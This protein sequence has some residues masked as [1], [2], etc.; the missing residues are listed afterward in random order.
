MKLSVLLTTSRSAT[1]LIDDG[2]KYF[3]LRGCTLTLNGEARGET[4]KSVF[5]LYG[6]TPSSEYTLT[7]DNG[8]ESEKVSFTTDC[9]SVTLNVRGFGARGDGV[10]DDT[11]FIQ[12]AILCCPP[13]GRVLIPKGRYSITHLFLKSHV[14]I[15]LK[16]GA[17]LAGSAAR[18]RT[19]VLPGV[20]QS[21]DGES[22][23][24]LASWEGNPLSS[25]ASLITGIGVED[26][27]IYGSGEIDGGASEENWWHEP[28]KLRGAWRPRMIYL[29][30]CK[31]VTVQGVT[32]KNSPSWNI[33]PFFSERLRFLELNVISPKDSPNT[34]GFDPESCK[35]VEMLGTWFSVGDDCVAIKSGKIYMGQRYSTPCED[36]RIAH[37]RMGDGH[38]GVTLGSEMAGGIRK[39]IVEDCE[40]EN[41]DRGLRV[42]TRRGRGENGIIDDILFRR[43]AMRG[44]L[45]PFVV[46]SFYFCDPDGKTEY[47]RTR[48]RLPV[49]ERTPHIKALRFS[50]IN[51]VDCHAA[52]G[53]FL[54]LPERGISHIEMKNVR[55]AFAE[56]AEAS[57]PAMCEGAAMCRKCGIILENVE[58]V[59]LSGVTIEGCEGERLIITNVGQLSDDGSS[60]SSTM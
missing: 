15:E 42:K 50:D 44:V 4:R 58:K 59:T 46:N 32:L 35:A 8:A 37:C 48:E 39:V 47:V 9:E 52:A 1:F 17:A 18:Q 5:S 33:H 41:T 27:A 43:I 11:P 21:A 38:G 16:E 60:I 36:I 14:R 13:Q 54:G 19:P 51:C 7:A 22:E 20:T 57:V 34:D 40:F 28:K 2:G 30:R 26:V 23:Y 3:L 55:I 56:D 25:Y 29:N 24:I 49:D 31:D 45:T 12:A 6:L 10:N 53:C